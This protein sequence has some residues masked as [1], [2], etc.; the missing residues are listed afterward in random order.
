MRQ[1][2]RYLGL[3]RLGRIATVAAM[4]SPVG[5]ALAGLAVGVLA[6][7]PRNLVRSLDPPAARRP[8]DTALLAM[9][10]MA[11]LGVLP[12]IDLLFGV[13]SMYT[14]SLG[15]VVAR[16]ARRSRRH[17]RRGAGP[18]PP[19]WPTPATSCWTGWATTRRRR[20][21]SWRSG[22]SRPRTSSPN[23]HL[24]LPISRRYWVQGFLAHNLTAVAREV[25]CIGPL[26]FFAYWRLTHVADKRM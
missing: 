4:P 26:A 18:L 10:P 24:F 21:G 15:A 17:R 2:L 14:H 25:L 23:L 12:D 13:H 1:E 7:G 9:L 11:A 6:A 20:S 3:P 16:A 19:A 8:I 5:H 22:R